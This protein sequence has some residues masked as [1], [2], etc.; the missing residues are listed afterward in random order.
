M[1]L[2]ERE[3]AKAKIAPDEYYHSNE[4]KAILD[5]LPT[6][7]PEGLRPTGSWDFISDYTSRCTNCCEIQWINHDE[8]PHYCPNCGARMDGG[9]G[10]G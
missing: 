5:D 7:D 1:E 8:E 6:I 9:E 10:R 3:A 4:V 2:I